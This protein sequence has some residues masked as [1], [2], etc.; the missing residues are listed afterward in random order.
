MTIS[1]KNWIKGT[2]VT[3]DQLLCANC[4][5]EMEIE[6]CSNWHDESGIFYAHCKCGNMQNIRWYHK[7]W[8][9]PI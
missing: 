8:K 4:G 1:N 6:H 2:N 3:K 9:E 7:G 5:K